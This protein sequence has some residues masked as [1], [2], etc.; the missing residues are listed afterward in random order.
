MPIV[1][2]YVP[3][4]P[5]NR[6]SNPVTHPHISDIWVYHTGRTH[7]MYEDGGGDGFGYPSLGAMLKDHG[8]RKSDVRVHWGKTSLAILGSA[9]RGGAWYEAGTLYEFGSEATYE[10]VEALPDKGPRL[11]RALRRL[12]REAVHVPL[13]GLPLRYRESLEK[14]EASLLSAALEGDRSR[15]RRAWRTIDRIQTV[16]YETDAI[17]WTPHVLTGSETT[18][19]V[20]HLWPILRDGLNRNPLRLEI[21]PAHGLERRGVGIV[22]IRTYRI[23]T[24]GDLTDEERARIRTLLGSEW[25]YADTAEELN[26]VRVLPTPRLIGSPSP[27]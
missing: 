26:P 17:P 4:A 16:L 25:I 24:H 14:A 8:L 1:R 7:V 18:A 10:R 27:P 6:R 9:A 21:D 12:I 20:R 13:P 3:P 11:T 2:E 15:A 5:P 22:T 19:L 23:H